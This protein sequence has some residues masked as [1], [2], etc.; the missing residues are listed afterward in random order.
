MHQSTHSQSTLQSHHGVQVHKLDSS[1]ET[2]TKLFQTV[3]PD[4][5]FS[6]QAAG[7]FNTQ[8][9]HIDAAIVSHVPRFVLAEWGHDSL[10]P[11]IQERLPPY[12]ERAKTLSYID[13][14]SVNH[15]IEFVGVA[16]G[17]TPLENALTSG[18]LGFDFTWHT[19]TLHGNNQSATN[20]FPASSA[21]W[22]SH[23]ALSIVQHWNEIRNSYLYVA[24]FLISSEQVLSTL[25]ALPDVGG[26]WTCSEVR[27]VSELTQEAERRFEMGFA[28]A[29]MLLL[30]RSVLCDE[31]VGAAK[32]FVEKDARERLGLEQAGEKLDQVITTAVETF[33]TQGKGGNCGCD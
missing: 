20:L 18:N 22:I 32:N 23:L 24:E 30:E 27:D 10:N 3:H 13:Q 15:E 31:E 21:S 17:L 6:T 5:I 11:E 25:Q 4:I 19:A 12:R 16:S 28:D 1:A 14:K 9:T 29:G 8:K 33:T 2:L 26:K 7:S